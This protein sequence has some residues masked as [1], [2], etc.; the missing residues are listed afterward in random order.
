LRKQVKDPVLRGK[1]RPQYK[2]ACK[3]LI[4]CSNFYPAISRDNA[5]LC[6]SGIERIEA[7]GVRSAD[8]Q[9]HE[10]DVLILATGFD[11]GKF[12]LPTK[13]TGEN[14]RGL[15]EFW[16]GTPRAHRSVGVP[17]FPNF[18]MIEGPTGPV[19]NISLILVSEYQ[20]DHLISVLNKMRAEA[21][22][23]V[24]PREEAFVEYNATMAQAAQQT[25]WFTGGCDSW[26]LDRNGIPNIYPWRPRQFRS[27]MR[28]PRWEEYELRGQTSTPSGSAT[29]ARSTPTS[30]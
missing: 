26:Y 23:E 6:T 30:A 28:H 20:I 11:V 29:V 22:T 3:R 9:L 18:W 15:E 13:V 5:S 24:A 27:E 7:Q 10:L 17:G 19:G 12:V 8:G 4:F 1:L 16:N 25:V 21:L 14:G 2:A